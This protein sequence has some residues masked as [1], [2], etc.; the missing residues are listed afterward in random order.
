MEAAGRMQLNMW[1]QPVKHINLY[2]NVPNMMVPLF[3]FDQVVEL[4]DDLAVNLRLMQSVPEYFNY[5]VLI[6]I[7]LGCIMLLW[8]ICSIYLCRDV[9]MKAAYQIS[10][11][12]RN[13]KEEMPLRTKERM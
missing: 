1:M 7:C 9:K 5:L 10:E 3:Y 2:E 11:N 8:S 12:T 13:I 6:L 4:K